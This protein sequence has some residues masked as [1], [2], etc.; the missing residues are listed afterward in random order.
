MT[1]AQ[2]TIQ[3]IT[4]EESITNIIT[5]DTITNIVEENPEVIV[6]EADEPTII[7]QGFPGIQGPPGLQG[8]ASDDPLAK[9]VDFVDDNHFYVGE[10]EPGT[11]P[12]EAL[13]RISYTVI[14]DDSNTI[15]TKWVNG[16]AYFINI[17]DDRVLG[18]YI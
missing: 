5:E 4:V 12:S 8:V 16:N 9:R 15:S 1:Y 18:N 7:A 11:I 17:W 3:N 10:A 2:P 13:W 6:I 14:S